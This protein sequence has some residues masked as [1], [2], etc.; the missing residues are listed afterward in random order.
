MASDKATV[1]TPT[2]TDAV[3]ELMDMDAEVVTAGAIAPI[4]KMDPSVI[5]KYA[6]EGKWPREIC[7]FV[8]S[9][10]RVKFFRWDFLMKG[11]WLKEEPEKT[12]SDRLDE[13]IELI[14][15]QNRMLMEIGAYV[16]T[17]QSGNSDGLEKGV[18]L[19]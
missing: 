16:K 1:F 14:R 19:E 15:V 18:S 6:K 12:D 13:I 10:T 2:Y 3:R 8:I 7:N 11:G 5:I 9:G 17:R 4:V